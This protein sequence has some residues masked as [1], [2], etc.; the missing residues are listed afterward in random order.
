MATVIPAPHT[1]PN[2]LLTSFPPL[3]PYSLS[4]TAVIFLLNGF[5]TTSP[6]FLKLI[7]S[8]IPYLA[9]QIPVSSWL[10]LPL[11]PPLLPL[12]VPCGG[13]TCVPKKETMIS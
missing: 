9:L 7:K 11:C 1:I 5:D 12:L 3:L 2:S 6:C 10:C 13:F 4:P 8:F